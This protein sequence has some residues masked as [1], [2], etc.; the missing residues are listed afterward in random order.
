MDSPFEE[1]KQIIL[2]LTENNNPVLHK[3]TVDK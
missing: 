1:I 2:D 3:A